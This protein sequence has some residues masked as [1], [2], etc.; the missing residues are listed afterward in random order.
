MN[1]YLISKADKGYGQSDE[2]FVEFGLFRFWEYAMNIIGNS[3]PP[4]IQVNEPKEAFSILSEFIKRC[5]SSLIIDLRDG[6]NT[7]NIDG[8]EQENDTIRLIWYSVD[9]NDPERFDKEEGLSP[10]IVRM[11]EELFGK[12]L[13]DQYGFTF[14]K[15]LITPAYLQLYSKKK[16]VPKPFETKN[17][18]IQ[19][20]PDHIHKLYEHQFGSYDKDPIL[21]Y[22]CRYY[23]DRGLT[24]VVTP[25]GCR[26]AFRPQ[27]FFPN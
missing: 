17:E 12:N 19:I 22:L 21:Q 9:K 11:G 3:F 8:V 10:E 4:V 5:G 25:K 20:L 27:N 24:A 1:R 18:R 13:E 6:C 26:D 16:K 7:D 23:C 14:D 2:H 15:M